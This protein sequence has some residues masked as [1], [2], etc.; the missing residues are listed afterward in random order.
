MIISEEPNPYRNQLRSYMDD[1]IEGDF[2]TATFF[3]SVEQSWRVADNAIRLVMTLI[4]A[5]KEALD[6]SEI[7]ESMRGTHMAMGFSD[8]FFAGLIVGMGE[9]FA[10]YNQNGAWAIDALSPILTHHKAADRMAAVDEMMKDYHGCGPDLDMSKSLGMG[11]VTSAISMAKHLKMPIPK[12]LVV[13]EEEKAEWTAKLFPWYENYQMARQMSL[14][15]DVHLADHLS[16]VHDE[17]VTGIIGDDLEE[18]L[19]LLLGGETS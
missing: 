3:T 7:P 10:L 11:G 13:T 5:P 15:F 19:R 1:D 16:A 18:Q 4:S 8:P 6:E 12:N 17:E 14:N 9:M 2:H